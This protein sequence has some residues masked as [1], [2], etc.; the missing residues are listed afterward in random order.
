MV[1]KVAPSVQFKVFL[2][3]LLRLFFLSSKIIPEEI[4]ERPAQRLLVVRQDNRIGNLLFITPFLTL[5]RKRF[6]DAVIHFIGGWH[7]P[8]LLKNQL[9]IN[10]IICFNQIAFLKKPWKFLWFFSQLRKNRYTIAFNMKKEF[11]FNNSLVCFLSGA[12]LLIGFSYTEIPCFHHINV[13][14]FPKIK[15]EPERLASLISSVASIPHSFPA[16]KLIIDEYYLD[17]TASILRNLFPNNDAPLIVVHPGGRGEK[18]WGIEKFIKLADILSH[19][20]NIKTIIL[21]GPDERKFQNLFTNSENLR[22]IIPENVLILAGIIYHA[23]TVFC[24][25][26]GALHIA[27]AL[28]IPSLSVFRY[29][30]AYRYA[31]QRGGHKVLEEYKDGEYN[32]ESVLDILLTMSSRN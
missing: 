5:L 26:S 14:D 17:K 13:P 8:D 16:M 1:R 3:K 15:Y 6:P 29:T 18:T 4:I 19:K 31:P 21:L 23:K 27:A 9:E 10:K 2:A 12:E 30:P 32:P 7:Y 24:N 20:K 22:V 11:S 28:G 25:D